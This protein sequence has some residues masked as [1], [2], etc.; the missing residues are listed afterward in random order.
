MPRPNT[1]PRLRLAAAGLA[2][3]GGLAAAAPALAANAAPAGRT[4]VMSSPSPSSTFVVGNTESVDTLN[5]FLGFTSQDYEVY[6]LIYD[7]LMDYGQLDYS[8]TPRLATS[9]SHSKDG[10]T[11]TYHIRKGVKFSDGVPLTAADVAYTFQ[12]NIKP[13]STEF[14][15]NEAYVGEIK[16]A[17]ATGKYTVVMKVKHYTPVMN[18][19][20]VPILPEHIWKKISEKQLGSFKNLN[21]VGSGAFRVA[22]FSSNQ[23]IRL[24]ANPDYWGGKPGIKTLVFQ[25]FDNPTAEKLALANGS[26][27]FA[28]NLTPALWQSLKG[29]P[30]VKLINATAGSFDELSFNNGAATVSG[31]PIGDGNPALKDVNVRHAISYALNIPILVKKVLLNTGIAGTSIIPPI[32]SQFHYSPP[33]SQ[34]YHYDPA[35]AKAI[36]DADGWK[37]GSNGIREKN[38]KQLSLRL[39][40]RNQSPT[41]VQDAPYIKGWLNEIG[42]KVTVT[43][44][45]D[46]QLTADIGNGQYDLFMWGWGVEPNPDFQLSVFTCGQRS[47]GSGPN[48]SPGWSDSF[49]CNPTYDKLYHQQQALDGAP[50]AKVVKQMQKML[51]DDDAYNV[52]YYPND[53]QAYRSDLFT[54]FAPSPDKPNGLYL[55]QEIQWWSYR[56]IR[57]VGSS[58]SLTAHNIGC[59]HAIGAVTARASGGV[60]GGLI[61]GIAAVGVAAGLGAWLVVSRRRR[62]TTADERE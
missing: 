1:R 6:G 45:S 40:V 9:W 41:Q 61:G 57:P 62:V 10:L 2:L 8:G 50:R 44:M 43:S 49:Y 27:S 37:M 58:P 59:E 48:Y 38:G 13:G 31:K 54:G 21:P 23:S 16:S 15:D 26:I 17:V 20:E 3:C 14:S 11:W 52:L 32:Y 22:S 36:L 18:R 30:G 56:C 19:L 24:T 42:I 34:Q 25:R 28:E 12:R 7:N 39:F 60:N 53:V 5:P 4:A 29:T 55:Y 33:A 35:K 46:S 51:Y 47:Y